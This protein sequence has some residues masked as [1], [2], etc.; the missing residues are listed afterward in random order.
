MR[1]LPTW[2]HSSN[3]PEGRDRLIIF[4]SI[5]PHAAQ[6]FYT[7]ALPRAGYTVS[8]S[9][10]MT[11]DDSPL[12]E[13]QFTGHGYGGMIFAGSNISG[14]AADLGSAAGKDLLEIELTKK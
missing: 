12:L 6:S 2:R 10:M 1:S 3:L 5:T 13:I 11:Q 14:V 4:S 8:S 7:A 9:A